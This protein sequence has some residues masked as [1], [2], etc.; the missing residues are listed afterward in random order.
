MYSI[1]NNLRHWQH[2]TLA[3][4]FLVKNFVFQDVRYLYRIKDFGLRDCYKTNAETKIIK[5]KC[6][7]RPTVL[8]PG[9]AGRV[10]PDKELKRS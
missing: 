8:P 7:S 9:L 5:N 4:I 6:P 3:I 1:N 2:M 10:Q